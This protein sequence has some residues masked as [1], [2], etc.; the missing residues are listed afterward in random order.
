MIKRLLNSLYLIL[1]ISIIISVIVVVTSLVIKPDRILDY[2][3]FDYYENKA[4]QVW[5]LQK[6]NKEAFSTEGVKPSVAEF[7]KELEFRIE[8]W[9]K[10]R[11]WFRA[12]FVVMITGLFLWVWYLFGLLTNIKRKKLLSASITL[13]LFLL[14]LAHNAFRAAEFEEFRLLFI[15]K[16]FYFLIRTYLWSVVLLLPVLLAILH[17]RWLYGK[18]LLL[19]LTASYDGF[20][21]FIFLL[22]VTLLS[23]YYHQDF[24][25][26]FYHG[27]FN[28][29]YT[30]NLLTVGIIGIILFGFRSIVN[31]SD[32]LRKIKN[33]L[34]YLLV[35]TF[36]MILGS[37]IP[38]FIVLFSFMLLEASERNRGFERLKSFSTFM[39][40][41]E[42]DFSINFILVFAVIHL[43]VWLI[44]Q[45]NKR[46]RDGWLNPADPWLPHNNIDPIPQEIIDGIDMAKNNKINA[47]NVGKVSEMLDVGL[48]KINALKIKYRQILDKWKNQEAL[49]DEDWR[50]EGNQK[51]YGRHYEYSRFSMGSIRN[52]Y[53]EEMHKLE[54]L[55]RSANEIKTRIDTDLLKEMGF[56][57]VGQIVT[58][59]LS[60]DNST[61][62]FKQFNKKLKSKLKKIKAD[63]FD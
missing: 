10:K 30:R 12:G 58:T 38:Y 51:G 31:Y 24:I 55:T 21:T 57:K 40:R 56:Q 28:F 25:N 27:N 5:H 4:L 63:D 50:K 49:S 60:Q 7:R 14:F 53:L 19:K 35:F 42:N 15:S 6:R 46:Y 52:R 2:D 8:N 11:F 59:N 62:V 29:V 33:Q 22:I 20:L 26:V 17:Y 45:N 3:C 16:G 18:R 39:N 54:W 13:S 9:R 36:R 47:E 61:G 34:F 41:A 43:V 37:I 23:L 44:L 1:F 32:V 48:N